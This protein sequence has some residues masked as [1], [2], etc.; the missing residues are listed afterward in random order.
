[1]KIKIKLRSESMEVSEYVEDAEI[2]A[3]YTQTELNK[4]FD[5][6]F[7]VYVR[8]PKNGILSNCLMID[9]YN[10]PLGSTDLQRLN[11]TSSLRFMMHLSNDFGKQ[12][13]MDKFGLE[14]NQM[15]YQL[16]HKGLT[17]R[18][19]NGKSPLDVCKKFV[20]WVSK[21]KLLIKSL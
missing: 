8:L 12:V 20:A 17:Y 15:S 16:K 11:A 18:K 13:K 3:T 6:K 9:L 1:M 10:V 14:L 7:S 5:E 21:N 4:I 19:I 2:A